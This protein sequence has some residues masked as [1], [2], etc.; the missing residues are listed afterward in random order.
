MRSP[1]VVV[2][3]PQKPQRNGRTFTKV[4]RTS[5]KRRYTNFTG[6]TCG[7]KGARTSPTYQASSGRAL[8]KLSSFCDSS[9]QEVKSSCG[10][11]TVVDNATM[12]RMLFMSA[13]ESPRPAFPFVFSS[14]NR[15]FNSSSTVKSAAGARGAGAIGSNSGG[16]RRRSA[17]PS[18]SSSKSAWGA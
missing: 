7:N 10:L 9:S 18:V 16:A 3:C 2:S 13:S 17:P 12:R 14:H 5:S 8:T 15:R 11:P 1:D 6:G 4:F